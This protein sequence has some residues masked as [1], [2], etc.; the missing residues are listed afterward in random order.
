[1]A[2][3]RYY[4]SKNKNN[5][6]VELD[7]K[8]IEG[9]D[10]TP[11]NSV[12]YDG[13]IVNKLVIIKQSFVEKILKKKIKKKLELYLKYIVDFIDGDDESG[14]TLREVLN[15]VTRY[16]DIINYRY[17]KHLGDKYIDMLTKKID[18][19]EYELK[20]KIYLIDEKQNSL[21]DYSVG[22]KSR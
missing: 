14:D 9:F 7:R 11:K 18:L 8:R 17:R 3:K 1:M 19:L 12:K 6:I 13:I 10:V 4:V 22:S 5:Q 2:N 20:V 15:D 16:K 21:E